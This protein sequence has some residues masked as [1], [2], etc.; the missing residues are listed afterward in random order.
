MSALPSKQTMSG[1]WWEAD[2]VKRTPRQ[3]G[4]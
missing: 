1:S 3:P 4:G 2:Y